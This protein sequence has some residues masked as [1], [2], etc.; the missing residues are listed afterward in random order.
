MQILKARY[1]DPQMQAELAKPETRRT[2]AS[3]ILTD[4]TVA[5]LKEYAAK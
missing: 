2:I 3:R 4:K 1:Q 5:K